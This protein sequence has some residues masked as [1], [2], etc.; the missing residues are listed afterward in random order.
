MKKNV[1]LI[2]VMMV[3]MMMASVGLTSCSKDDDESQVPSEY[4]GS[5]ICN[6]YCD[7]DHR[8]RTKTIYSD[9]IFTPSIVTLNADG[10]CSGVGMVVNGD[11]T[12]TIDRGYVFRDFY[13]ARLIFHQN[14]KDDTVRL[15]TYLD[16]LKT[17]YVLLDGFPDI[18][19]IFKK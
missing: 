15:Q 7:F 13:N 17:A 11:A 2:C 5:W 8:N 14:E 16:N 19:F 3:A 9:G 12:W 18:W 6:S 4:V 10:T 1:F